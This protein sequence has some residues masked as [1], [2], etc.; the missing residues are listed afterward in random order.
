MYA[1]S[2]P[3]TST[4][5][6]AAWP[7]PRAALATAGSRRRTLTAS[8]HW[9]SPLVAY[10]PMWILTLFDLSLTYTGGLNASSAAL[11]LETSVVTSTV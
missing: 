8:Q 10:V 4:A 11:Y 5:D 6:P 9:A 2:Q 3:A 1:K 7:V